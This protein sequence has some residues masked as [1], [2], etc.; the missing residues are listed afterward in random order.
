MTTKEHYDRH[1][2]GFYSWMVGDFISAQKDQQRF[3]ESLSLRPASTANAI[4]LGAGHGIQ[5]VS[6]AR[7]G[8]KVKAI[9]FNKQLL[10]ELGKNTVGLPVEAIEDDIRFVKKHADP[11]PEVIVCCGDTLTHLESKGEINQL[12]QDCAE[13]LDTSGR[14][15]LSIRDYS[16]E[17]TGDSRFIPVRSDDT[18]ILTCFLEY[19]GD[20]V[21]VSDLLHT[22]TEHG[23]QQKV[24]SYTKV[25]IS[26]N[27]VVE[28]IRRVGLTIIFHE[29]VNQLTTLVARK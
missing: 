18:R 5:A 23:W 10:S 9:D 19:C 7:L 8:F 15:I 17:L 27:E 26:P 25:R 21:R 29:P 14:L 22:K 1:L 4:D 3:F 20:H 13:I 16:T 24:S 12:I 28:Q 11:K 6:L 2:G